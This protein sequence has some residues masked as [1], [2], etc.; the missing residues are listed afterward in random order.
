MQHLVLTV[1]GAHYSASGGQHS[2]TVDMP[3]LAQLSCPQL[4]RPQPW[5][6]LPLSLYLPPRKKTC[7]P[8]DEP[9]PPRRQGAR[10]PKR[11]RRRSR[12][13]LS[14]PPRRPCWPLGRRWK[15]RGRWTTTV[16]CRTAARYRELERP[17][18][19]ETKLSWEA[20]RDD[21][22]SSTGARRLWL[23]AQSDQHWE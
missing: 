12:R 6:A 15:A 8:R 19:H 11:R 3:E 22:M 9:P 10:R 21:L 17:A 1:N 23:Y 16:A 20:L 13:T 4:T 5:Q 7:L 18:C 2:S 14:L